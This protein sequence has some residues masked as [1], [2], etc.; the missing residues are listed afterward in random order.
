MTGRSSGP[1]SWP[2]GAGPR[3]RRWADQVS[4]RT[5]KFFADGVIEAGTA[6][7]LAPYDDIPGD[8]PPDQPHTCGLP[9]WPPEELAAAAAAFDADGFQLHIHAI[10]D[11]GVRA[12]LDAVAH[13]AAVNGPRDR[14]PVIA[15]TQLVDPADLPRFAE[16]GVV[17][18]FEP[19]W[20]QLDAVQ[21]ELTI[22][23]I[24]AARGDRQY[25]MASLLAS[26]AVL[27]MGTDWPVSSHR[28]LEGL[29]Q[30]VAGHWV[31]HE[32]LPVAAALSACTAGTAY[33]AFEE[34][35]WGTIG[36]GRRADLVA[37]AADPHD[38]PP[39]GWPDLAVVGTWLGGRRTWPA[40]SAG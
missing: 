2:P 39:D 8:I 22:P 15:H 10:G 19:L 3:S 13:V 36:L 7:L 6:A 9:V 35:A 28:P 4:V 27:S 34:H 40:G 24:G 30:A 37:L 33:Q 21:T 12:A 11:A 16:L 29:P 32:R 23:R 26:G 18:N 1:P 38:V 20:A 17:A 14:R 5:V 25:P 31:A